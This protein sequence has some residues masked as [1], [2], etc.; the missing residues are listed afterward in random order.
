MLIFCK[1]QAFTLWSGSFFV[2]IVATGLAG[3]YGSYGDK[4][5]LQ[6]SMHQASGLLLLFMTLWMAGGLAVF[7][8]TARHSARSKLAAIA[9]TIGLSTAVL[10]TI[11]ILSQMCLPILANDIGARAS[12]GVINLPAVYRDVVVCVGVVLFGAGFIFT[13]GFVHV[14]EKNSEFDIWNYTPLLAQDSPEVLEWR[15]DFIASMDREV[16]AMP[17]RQSASEKPALVINDVILS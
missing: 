15:R 7:A 12:G 10:I 5:P 17:N 14:D 6:G 3:E 4:L 16:A 8:I 9:A 11:Q 13:L 1:K 2:L